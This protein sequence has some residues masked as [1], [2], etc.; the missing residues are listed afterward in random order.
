MSSAFTCRLCGSG[1]RN[2]LLLRHYLQEAGDLLNEES[3]RLLP[4][5]EDY[6]CGLDW[7]GNVRQL[8]NYSIGSP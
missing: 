5:A 2:S 7:Q 3:K 1:G 4:E 8:E 6:L